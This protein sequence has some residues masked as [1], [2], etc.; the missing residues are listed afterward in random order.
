M[1]ET[2]ARGEDGDTRVLET[3]TLP[4]TADGTEIAVVVGGLEV[5]VRDHHVF[6]TVTVEGRGDHRAAERGIGVEPRRIGRGHVRQHAVQVHQQEMRAIAREIEGFLADVD[7]VLISVVVDID[8]PEVL[9]FHIGR[10]RG[11]EQRHA[12][13]RGI[14]ELDP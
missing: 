7:Q 13:R 8:Q 12:R 10:R 4:D 11:A 9:L 2:T 3:E 1:A 14:G 6:P 5:R